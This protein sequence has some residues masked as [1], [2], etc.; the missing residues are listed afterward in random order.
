MNRSKS[1]DKVNEWFLKFTIGKKSFSQLVP[2]NFIYHSEEDEPNVLAALQ[3]LSDWVTGGHDLICIE[4]RGI[5]I[6]HL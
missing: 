6:L 4:K 1:S 3:K 2:A 5:I